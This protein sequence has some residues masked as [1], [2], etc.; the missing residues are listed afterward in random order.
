MTPRNNVFVC[1][2]SHLGEIE[3][4]GLRELMMQGSDASTPIEEKATFSYSWTHIRDV[5]DRV[6]RVQ[7]YPPNSDVPTKTFDLH[8]EHYIPLHLW[9]SLTASVIR[10]SEFV[11]RAN[12]KSRIRDIVEAFELAAKKHGATQRSVADF[13]IDEHHAY[14]SAKSLKVIREVLYKELGL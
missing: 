12:E 1:E 6:T 4:I 2:P 5:G 8:K 3:V 7:Y 11:E 13:N 9:Y 14:E 10:H